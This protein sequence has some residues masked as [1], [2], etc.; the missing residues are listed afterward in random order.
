MNEMA[1]PLQNNLKTRTQLS[2]PRR[3]SVLLE[4]PQRQLGRPVPE[5]LVPGNSG[6]YESSIAD[7][8]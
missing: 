1:T 3:L 4:L 6:M 2:P 7:F 8:W 5:S